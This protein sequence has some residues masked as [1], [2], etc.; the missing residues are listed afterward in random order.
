MGVWGFKGKSKSFN[1]NNKQLELLNEIKV[2]MFYDPSK[3]LSEQTA[4]EKQLDRIFSKPETAEKYIAEMGQYKH[5]I[6]Q[7]AS[8]ASL[9]I[10]VVG[11]LFSLGLDLADSALY[12]SEGDKYNAGLMLAF[13]L[14]P[15]G[16]LITKIPAVKKI[17]RDGLAN[18]LKKTKTNSKLTADEV[19]TLKDI[20][21]AE[22]ML[23]SSMIKNLIYKLLLKL[24]LSKVV[25]LVYLLSKQHPTLFKLS[26]IIL[27]IA[28]IQISFDKLAQYYGFLPNK[29][30]DSD[31]KDIK[32][33]EKNYNPE[34]IVEAMTNYID[35]NLNKLSPEERDSTFL[36]NTIPKL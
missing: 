19:N 10:P 22:K 1:M 30:S 21:S 25:K 26:S 17:G 28:G 35:K 7:V 13:S 29:L 18:L 23:K 34:K 20:A 32:K 27:Q 5:E 8:I 11:P 14:I 15:F 31:E 12:A 16:E 33:A 24:P 4:Y 3:T 9:F 36:R 2:K 6:I